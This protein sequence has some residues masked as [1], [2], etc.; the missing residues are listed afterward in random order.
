MGMVGTRKNTLAAGDTAFGTVAKLRF[1][2][3]PFRIVAPEAA[4]GASFEEHS[5]ADART[6][7]QGEPL[8]VEDDVSSVHC[9]TVR[10]ESITNDADVSASAKSAGKRA[11]F[12]TMLRV[13]SSALY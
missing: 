8:Y 13:N 12:P 5:C 6:I 3:L 4:H 9:D 10:G 7:V 2:V 11:S 1:R